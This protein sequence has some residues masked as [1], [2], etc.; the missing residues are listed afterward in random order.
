MEEFP[1]L[2]ERSRKKWVR[3][4]LR[5]KDVEQCELQI[6][7]DKR[8]LAILAEDLHFSK[9]IDHA[10]TLVHRYQLQDYLQKV[11][12]KGDVDKDY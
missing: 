6:C 11:E 8:L 5:N 9:K 12:I 2:I 3:Y 10:L 1:E 7:W 4:L